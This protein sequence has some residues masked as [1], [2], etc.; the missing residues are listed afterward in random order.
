MG[1]ETITQILSATLSPRDRAL[2][3]RV[4]ETLGCHRQLHDAPISVAVRGG[5]A[6]VHGA[7]RSPEERRLLRRTIANV[8][9]IHAVWDA[10]SLE[11]GRS[12]RIIDIGCGNAKQM[13]GAIGVDA[14]PHDGVDVVADLEQGLPF[15]DR[16]I[17]HVFAVHV[18]EHIRGL[19]AVMNEIHRVLRPDGVLHVLVPS[20]D[21]VNA[22]A[23]PTHVRF[24]NRQTFKYFCQGRPGLKPFRPESVSSDAWNVYADLSPLPPDA[25][26]PSAEELAL[27]F[28]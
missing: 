28:D 9:G 19:V 6:H 14:F 8:R 15:D 20:A 13:P 5:V 11:P 10:L 2:T 25:P 16:S 18:L 27:F 4:V 7:A 3:A 12:A 26:L 1:S 17:D 21:C 23:D 24:F 22:A